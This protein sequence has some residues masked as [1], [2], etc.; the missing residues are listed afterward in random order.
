V[1]DMRRKGKE[2]IFHR[3]Y[4]GIPVCGGNLLKMEKVNG[5]LRTWTLD[6]ISLN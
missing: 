4:K 6:I 5:K 2:I 1:R 3:D